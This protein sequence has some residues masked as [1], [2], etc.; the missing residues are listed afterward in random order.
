MNHGD[1][2]MVELVRLLERDYDQTGE[3]IRSLVGTIST[4]RGWAVTVWLALLGVAVQQ[5]SAALAALAGVALGPFALLDAYHSW[6][7]GQALRHARGLEQLSAD[8]YRAL[9]RGGDDEDLL[10]DFNAGMAAHRFGLY[11][12]FRRFSLPELRRARPR[13][14]FRW[15]YPAL[16]CVAIGIAVLIALLG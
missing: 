4:T 16:L 7:Y 6:L 14:V 10:L 5:E 15:F 1:E 8:Y 9:E 13:L 11:S 12:H 2:R 3:F